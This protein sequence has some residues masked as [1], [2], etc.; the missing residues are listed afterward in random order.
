MTTK[1]YR[2]AVIGTGRIG[3]LLESDPKRIKPATHFGL[4]SSHPRTELVAVCD[5][6]Q[7]KFK[8]AK[9]M[10]LDVQTYTDPE[11][12]LKEIKPDIVSI[13][14]WNDTHY[15]MMKLA[16]RHKVPAIVLEKPIAEKLEH[17]REI[18][19]EAKRNGTH[20][21]INHRRRFDPLV[22][23]MVDEINK[24]II[25]EILQASIFYVFG[26]ITTGTHLIDVLRLFLGEIK[27]VA[28]FPN[29][30]E[31]FAPT[32]DP[33]V[34]AFIG[35][36]SGIKASFQSLD[37]KDYDIFQ[38]DFYGR[39]GKISFKNIGRDFEII[40]PKI[41]PEHTGFIELNDD[42]IECRGGAPRNQF[43]FLGDNVI[44]CLEGRATSLSTGEDSLRA[45]EILLAMQKSVE[46]GNKVVFV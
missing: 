33:C 42:E 16:L 2:A 30:K 39:K 41:S 9:T 18:V 17:A 32:D 36:E 19:E 5:N 27:W 23:E 26:L 21:F 14:T 31:H 46:L 6:D 10:K 12:L 45:L 20:L 7:K 3:M 28:A 35:F 22:Y 43:M 29:I 13:S 34:D 40:R 44:D 24:G 38:I 8:I 11:E 4:W 37:M 1:K 15:Q 25:G